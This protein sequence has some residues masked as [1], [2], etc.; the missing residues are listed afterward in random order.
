MK[1]LVLAAPV[2]TAATFRTFDAAMAVSH[3]IHEDDPLKARFLPAI[4]PGF[5]PAL[6]R[7]C[8]VLGVKLA[9]SGMGLPDWLRAGPS[10]ARAA[11]QNGMKAW[12]CRA[13]L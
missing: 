3:L 8:F 6:E 9:R 11:A 1:S 13:S 5:D 4:A 2:S 7:D 12:Q 10:W